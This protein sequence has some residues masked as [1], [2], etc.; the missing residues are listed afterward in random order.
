MR[1]EWI[2]VSQT[3]HKQCESS[4]PTMP[5][6]D[7]IFKRCMERST[8][9]ERNE[10]SQILSDEKSSGNISTSDEFDKRHLKLND[11]QLS[12]DGMKKH[13]ENNIPSGK[14]RDRDSDRSWD[15]NTYSISWDDF[16][17][18]MLSH[19]GPVATV[20]ILQE[21]DIPDDGISPNF[22]QSAVVSMLLDRN[23]RSV[24]CSLMVNRVG[25]SRK[26][27]ELL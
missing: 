23:K 8:G 2:F 15:R 3:L 26:S 10:N 20:T 27:R 12:C 18:L 6:G 13:Q 1:E 16:A 17:T 11:K 21:C 4:G 25:S 7:S 14:R 22:H 19:L 24:V 5:D 9:K